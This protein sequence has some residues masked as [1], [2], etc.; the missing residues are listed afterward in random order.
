MA[1][2]FTMLN[3]DMDIAAQVAAM[4]RN[5]QMLDS[6]VFTK[7]IAGGNGQSALISGRLPDKNFGELV[8]DSSGLP[9]AL[10][11][12]APDDKRPGLWIAK[13]GYNVLEELKST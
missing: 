4:N 3:E 8:Y 12:Q 2:R 1:N 10:F 13:S 9:S 11:G 7:R 6:E 5:F